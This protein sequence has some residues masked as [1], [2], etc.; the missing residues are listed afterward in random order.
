MTVT[1]KLNTFSHYGMSDKGVFRENNE[2]FIGEADTVNGYLFIVCDGIGGIP[3]GEQAAKIA[4]NSIIEF[5][6]GKWQE[7]TG[8]LLEEA[9][10]FAD[11]EIKRAAEEMN[12]KDIPG[13]TVAL[14]LIRDNNFYYAHAGDSRIYFSA[15]KKIF[16]LTNDHSYVEELVKQSIITKKQAKN[17]PERNKITNGLGAF[18]KLVPEVCKSPISPA[19]NNYILICSDGFSSFVSLKETDKIISKKIS[20][21]EKVELLIQ[22]AIEKG[23]NDNISIFLINFF[24]TGNTNNK[25]F[26]KKRNKLNRKKL[27]FIAIISLIGLISLLIFT[28]KIITNSNNI[29][30]RFNSGTNIESTGKIIFKEQQTFTTEYAIKKLNNSYFM[31]KYNTEAYKIITYSIGNDLHKINFYEYKIPVKNILVIS[32]GTNINILEDI[33]KTNIISIL[34]ANDKQ[35]LFINTGEQIII[36]FSKPTK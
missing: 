3:A 8:K 11:K 17:H 16:K 31:N 25:A 26:G 4:V 6:S 7:D 12:L 1:K 28:T 33:F 24:N 20:E 27:A 32:L 29:E 15:G 13:T 34:K 5:V 23:S 14:V 21:K 18:Q 36:P 30:I 10:Y 19:D 35:E 2:D 22:K 9:C